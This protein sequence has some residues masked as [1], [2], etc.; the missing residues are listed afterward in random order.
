MFLVQLQEITAVL[1]NVEAFLCTI[2]APIQISS[3]SVLALAYF[4]SLEMLYCPICMC[5]N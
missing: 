2:L 5:L 3:A 1:Q 4:D